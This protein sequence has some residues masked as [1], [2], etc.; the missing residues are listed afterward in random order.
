MAV[1]V[2]PVDA[3]GVVATVAHEAAIEQADLEST[4]EDQEESIEV[5]PAESTEVDQVASIEVGDEV[6]AEAVGAGQ[7][8]VAN[9]QLHPH[10]LRSLLLASKAP[11]LTAHAE[12]VNNLTT[13][14]NTCRS[15]FSRRFLS[16]TCC[17][18]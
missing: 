2:G 15:R 18:R 1:E 7:P 9:L 16:A 13:Q 3:A 5:D 14:P 6:V 10:R 4:G 11:H 17:H 12:T 8:E